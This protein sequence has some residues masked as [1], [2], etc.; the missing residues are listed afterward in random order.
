[1]RV[2]DISQFQDSLVIHFDTEGS[3]IN[4]YTL[5][6]TLV[7]FADAAK[8]ANTAINS[9]CDV[10]I[11][12]EALGPG[13]FR[14]EVRALYTSAKNLLSNQI[15]LGV[16]IGVLGN[17]IYERI[18]SLDN[19]ISIEVHTDEVVISRG[20]DRVVVPRTVY[21]ATR[22]AEKNPA[23]VESVARTFKAVAADEKIAAIGLIRS[24]NSPS[25]DIPITRGE[26][27]QLAVLQSDDPDVRIVTE[28]AEL[29]IVKAI[30]EKSK[31]K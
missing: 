13:S 26:L 24:M 10:E 4:A 20:T 7:A 19:K 31:R 11:V 18:F 30:L 27:R 23:F 1:M 6:S 12:V 2:V 21:D 14:A 3:R 25:L 28:R 8:A 22:K 5:A 29:Q 15:V 16:V 17:Y 9:G